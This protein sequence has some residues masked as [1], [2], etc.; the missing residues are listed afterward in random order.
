VFK[1]RFFFLIIVS[2]MAIISF[3]A[4][5][6]YSVVSRLKWHSIRFEPDS[7]PFEFTFEK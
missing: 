7:S 3:G 2:A 1:P 5:R 4:M 6:R